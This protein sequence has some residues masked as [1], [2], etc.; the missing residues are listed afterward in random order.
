MPVLAIAHSFPGSAIGWF[1]GLK[2]CS[3]S[4]HCIPTNLL[5]RIIA[6]LRLHAIRINTDFALQ[7]C[8]NVWL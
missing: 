5:L 4:P 3:V 8:Y 7:F 2:G 6:Q 1:P